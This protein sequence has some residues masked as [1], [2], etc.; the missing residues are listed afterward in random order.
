MSNK[1]SEERT[2]KCRISGCDDILGPS[3]EDVEEHLRSTHAEDREKIRESYSVRIE[4]DAFQDTENDDDGDDKRGDPTFVH[5][6]GSASTNETST[7]G[8]NTSTQGNSHRTNSNLSSS[9]ESAAASGAADGPSASRGAVVGNKFAIFGIGGAGNHILDSMLMRRDTLD[10]QE[11]PLVRAWKGGMQEYIALNTNNA[12]V[13]NTYYA[14]HDQNMNSADTLQRCVLGPGPEGAGENPIIGATYVEDD[15]EQAPDRTFTRWPFNE[16]DIGRAQ[17]VMFLH[18]VVGGTG[19]GSTPP[20]AR[21]I[22]NEVLDNQ[23]RSRYGKPILSFTI[24]PNKKR[25]EKMPTSKFAENCGFGFGRIAS[26]VDLI[27]P[28]GN[29]QLKSVNTECQIAIDGPENVDHGYTDVNQPLVQFIEAF[30]LTSNPELRNTDAMESMRQDESNFSGGDSGFDV[31]DAF[32]PIADR[33][34]LDEI[35]ERQPGVV[36]APVFQRSEVRSIDESVL[37][38]LIESAINHGKL[39]EFDPSS[40]WGAVFIIF[41]P[42]DLLDSAVDYIHD[43]RAHELLADALGTEKVEVRF[44]YAAIEH[45]DTIH[46]AGLFWNPRMSALESMYESAKEARERNDRRGKG[47]SSRWDRVETVYQFLGRENRSS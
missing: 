6:G 31:P 23:R 11:S 35:D 3:K 7:N 39:V 33:Y 45:V 5:T 46:I 32:Q 19:T 27:V 4:R 29:S 13:Q 16:E 47:F 12:E 22:R 8:E 38:T 1:E 24:L 15:I 25:I 44:Q 20:L 26:E 42:R 9:S 17:A 10:E 14:N 30:M 2:Q 36:G 18:S 40:A 37:R 21:Y 41:G 28:F 43:F 34:P